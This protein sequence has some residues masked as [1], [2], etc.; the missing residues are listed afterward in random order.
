MFEF[1]KYASA[2]LL[3]ISYIYSASI[4]LSTSVRASEVSLDYIFGVNRLIY[5]ILA[6]SITRLSGLSQ[7]T[8]IG[9]SS[10]IFLDFKT[11]QTTTRNIQHLIF[12]NTERRKSTGKRK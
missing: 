11:G 8:W 2:W 4:T 1:A 3:N 10:V 12:Q 6:L 5:E 7:Q 9:I